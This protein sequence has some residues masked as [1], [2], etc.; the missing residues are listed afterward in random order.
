M[1]NRK[2]LIEEI[3]KE[4]SRD[5]SDEEV[6]RLLLD[7]KMSDAGKERDLKFGDRIADR[8]AKFAGSWG[9]IL[10]FFFIII[11][12]MIYNT[13]SQQ[14]FDV[15]PFILLNLILSCL[16]AIQAPIIMMS[17]NRQ[18]AKDRQNVEN[19]Y[20]VNLKT[21]IMIEDLYHKLNQSIDNQERIIRE[22]EKNNE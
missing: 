21:E 10:T 11:M 14:K 16:A 22:L 2:K 3:L 7:K 13:L 9:F 17:Q 4:V 12:W 5:A 6:I 20:R 1:K 15:Y 8:L 19:D 18:E